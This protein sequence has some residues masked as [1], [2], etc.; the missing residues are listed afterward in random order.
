LG[1][2]HSRL[3]YNAFGRIGITGT[4]VLGFVLVTVGCEPTPSGTIVPQT[5]IGGESG[6]PILATQEVES[7]STATQKAEYIHTLIPV[8]E[9]GLSY[10]GGTP[11][12]PV[13]AG[14]PHLFFTRDDLATLR[15]KQGREPYRTWLRTPIWNWAD[16][17]LEKGV[18]KEGLLNSWIF[19]RAIYTAFIYQL[20]GDERYGQAAVDFLIGVTDQEFQDYILE[21]DLTASMAL[22]R[23]CRVHDWTAPAMSA[24]QKAAS[25]RRI[26][27]MVDYLRVYLV[28]K[29]A[30]K[31]ESN[32]TLKAA[33]SISL[34]ALTLPD[35][36]QAAKWLAIGLHRLYKGFDA[37]L[38]ED[39]VY[40][41]GVSYA[42]YATEEF[43]DFAL[44]YEHLTGINVL[45]SDDP[46]VGALFDAL[47]KLRRPDGWGPQFDDSSRKHLDQKVI[48]HLLDDPAYHVWD[49]TAGDAPAGMTGTSRYYIFYDD[50]I[51]PQ[52]P[53]WN[54]TQFLLGENIAVFRRDW[55]PESSYLLL[56]GETNDSR[57]HGHYD[58]SSFTIYAHSAQLA[59]DG[60]YAGYDR[61]HRDLYRELI[62]P[63]GH[64][65]VLADGTGPRE[66]GYLEA[67]DPFY[68]RH[69]FATP[70][71]DGADVVG[72]YTYEGDMD[73]GWHH[74]DIGYDKVDDVRIVRTVLYPKQM[75]LSSENEYFIVIDTVEGDEVHEYDWVLHADGQLYGEGGRERRW[76]VENNV[77]K[78]VELRTFFAWPDELSI[79]ESQGLHFIEQGEEWTHTYIRA[80]T[81][82]EDTQ[83]VVI[84][85]PRLVEGMADPQITPVSGSGQV[86]GAKLVL[87]EGEDE[88]EDLVI[89][90]PVAGQTAI[91]S[92]T[93]DARIAFRRELNGALRYFAIKEGSTFTSAG[94][95]YLQANEVLP[96]VALQY[97]DMGIEGFIE[98]PEMGAEI[99]LYCPNALSVWVD[100][101]LIQLLP[102]EGDTVTLSLAGR[103]SIRIKQ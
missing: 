81:E 45:A 26:E 17:V 50:S 1:L 75:G 41:E 79:S 43:I 33:S 94:Q 86:H 12:L 27:A 90:Q 66:V 2:G 47:I 10:L 15:A 91:A 72:A 95:T 31:R 63:E 88:L 101:T 57:G 92:V 67:G 29:S 73:V 23:W 87:R 36:P 70:F 74:D 60:G 7:T 30:Q 100:D 69:C 48:A 62:Y 71:L 21:D 18:R 76:Q 82:A 32:H 54:P 77:G 78:L 9:P 3:R 52:A 6:S 51:Q 68:L 28:E 8:G 13:Y 85:Y 20:S 83:F 14:H 34:A 98:A 80:R 49:A 44:A 55:S 59:L 37:T 103:H 97:S 96:I 46:P 89:A 58:Q 25:V 5:T 39:G 93:S 38:A 53:A 65:L 99:T 64:N 4:L 35:H 11:Q 56:L 42:V 24:E 22:A 16:D 40:A 84:L 19:R 102:T 61:T